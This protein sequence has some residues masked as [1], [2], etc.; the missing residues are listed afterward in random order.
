MTQVPLH[1]T[2][3][4]IGRPI[5]N[6]RLYVLGV[7]MNPVPV[8]CQGEICVAGPGVARGYVGLARAHRGRFVPDPFSNR[9]GDVLYKTGDR[10][11]YRADGTI[12][13]LGRVDR[14]IKFRGFRIEPCEIESALARH[15]H[16]QRPRSWLWREGAH[17]HLVGYS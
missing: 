3:I 2:S 7:D 9:A 8:G 4:P 10:G 5:S 6:T 13:I 1:P 15:P 16:G 11:R 14:Q 17:R 12:D